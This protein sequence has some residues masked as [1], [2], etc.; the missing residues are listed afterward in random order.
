MSAAPLNLSGRLGCVLVCCSAAGA[1]LA[2]F[3]LLHAMWLSATPA[4]DSLRSTIERRA[5]AAGLGL[6]VCAA[7]LAAGAWL[8]W[9]RLRVQ[10]PG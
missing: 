10:D 6:G 5:E 9:R 3:V 2:A 8:W 7:G 4:W 1:A